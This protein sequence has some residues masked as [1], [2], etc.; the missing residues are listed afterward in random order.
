MLYNL[1]ADSFH[2]NFVA[3][4][5]RGKCTFRWKIPF[6]AYEAPLRGLVATYGVYLMLIGKLV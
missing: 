3:D 1:A 2:I 6:C 4:F 5:L